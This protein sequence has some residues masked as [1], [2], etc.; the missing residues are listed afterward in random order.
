MSEKRVHVW[1]QRF[2]DRTILMLQWLD[3]DTGRRKSKSAGTADEGEAEKARGDLEYELTHG[4]YQEASRMSWERFRE[5]FEEE[6]VV[7]LRPFTRANYGATFDLFEQ[8]CNPRLLRGVSERTVSLFAAGMRKA[9]GRH[10]GSVGMMASSIKVRL[11]FLH[12]A[13]RWAVRQKMIPAV[14]E[15]PSIKVPKKRPAAVP[16]ESWEKLLDKAP[17][18]NMRAYLLAGWLGGLRLAE[19][20]ALEREPTEKAPYLDLAGDRIVFPAEFVKATEDQWVPLD[21]ALRQALQALPRAGKR[22]FRFLDRK[23]APLSVS[24]VSQR[25]GKLAKRAGVKL[26]MKAL[27]RGFGCRYAGKV[28]A[29]VLQ[30]LMRHASIKTTMDYYANVDEA[31]MRAV[32]GQ[33]CNTS[34]NTEADQASAAEQ[35]ED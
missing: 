35:V 29:Q 30:K 27:R 25:V 5:L 18:A 28:A 10:L 3:P 15:F 1:V 16:A 24:G 26:T 8:V 12:T 4:K 17:D 32:L 11:Q 31:A 19:A 2:P 13:L 22:V 34:R 14:P 20:W 6:Y 23:G 21:P 9:P 7:G 33:R